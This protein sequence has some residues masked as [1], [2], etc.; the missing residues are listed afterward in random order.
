M[1]DL[2]S[3]QSLDLRGQL[4]EFFQKAKLQ[5]AAVLWTCCF[6]GVQIVH[7]LILSFHI[8]TALDSFRG[9]KGQH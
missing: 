3:L 8:F 9:G 6:L 4:F 2:P 5:S 7:R 1:T